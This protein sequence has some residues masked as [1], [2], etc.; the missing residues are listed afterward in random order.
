MVSIGRPGVEVQAANV[1]SED[2]AALRR[3]GIIAFLALAF[4]LAWLPFLSIPLGFGSAAYILMPVAP[5]IACVVV[6]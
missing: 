5:A 4:G 6:R 1:S 2:E 3:R